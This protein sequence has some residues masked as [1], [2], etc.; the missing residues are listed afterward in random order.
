MKEPEEVR[1]EDCREWLVLACFGEITDRERDL[2][3]RHLARCPECRAEQADLSRLRDLY[4]DDFRPVSEA[5]LADARHDLMRELSLRSS[6]GSRLRDRFSLSLGGWLRP[7]MVGAGA[8]VL[9]I[10]FLA[11]R[12]TTHPAAGSDPDPADAAITAL[13]LEELSPGRYQIAFTES[14]R[15]RLVG[16]IADPAVQRILAYALI[17]DA[18]PGSRLQA[19]NLIATLGSPGA[20][21]AEVVNALIGALRTDPNPVVR[22]QALTA[23]RQHPPTAETKQAWVDALLHDDNA[24]VRLQAI[25]ALQSLVAGGGRLDPELVRRLEQDPAGGPDDYVRRQTREFLRQ[26][27]HDSF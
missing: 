26:T 9:V 14:R 10:G 7:A 25:E 11:G 22:M 23:L 15:R 16:D 24:G 5:V 27:G 2:L 13:Q 6:A 19:V 12:L 21:D 3:D 8:A 1:H 4:G 18:N 17:T 20:V